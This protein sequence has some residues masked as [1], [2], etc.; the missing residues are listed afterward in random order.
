MT[1]WGHGTQHLHPCLHP[2]LHPGSAPA[3]LLATPAWGHQLCPAATRGHGGHA[4][5]PGHPKRRFVSPTRPLAFT[6]LCSLSW[7]PEGL[8]PAPPPQRD[9]LPLPCSHWNDSHVLGPCHLS[10]W[11]GQ[12][13]VPLCSAASLAHVPGPHLALTPF[14]AVGRSRGQRGRAQLHLLS[15]LPSS[16]AVCQQGSAPTLAE[17]VLE[18]VPCLFH[19]T[20]PALSTGLS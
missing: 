4:H 11:Q 1:L 8:H 6:L 20:L 5:G 15:H 16:V 3:W 17:P 7:H 18:D 9:V 19:P 12:A 13:P 2:C 14:Q 10:G